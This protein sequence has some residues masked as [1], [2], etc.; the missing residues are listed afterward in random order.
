MGEAFDRNYQNWNPV[1]IAV[2]L[3]FLYDT[4]GY[5]TFYILFLNLILWYGS[6][7]LIILSLYLKYNKKRTVFLFIQVS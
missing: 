1:I 5:H 3:S 2:F 6:I 7:T 4:F